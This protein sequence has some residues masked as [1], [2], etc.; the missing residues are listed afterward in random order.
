MS[1]SMPA[2]ARRRMLFVALLGAAIG[3]VLLATVLIGAVYLLEHRP[4]NHNP[5]KGTGA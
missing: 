5:A 1:R 2:I 3:C 4:A